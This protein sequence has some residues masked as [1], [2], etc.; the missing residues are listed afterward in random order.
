MIVI[1]RSDDSRDCWESAGE[2]AVPA[3]LGFGARS[4]PDQTREEGCSG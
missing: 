4:G 3:C 1:C 2:V